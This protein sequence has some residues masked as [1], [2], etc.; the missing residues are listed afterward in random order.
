MS[1]AQ[2]YPVLRSNVDP[3]SDS[4]VRNH[5]A[6]SAALGEVQAALAK[7]NLSGGDKYRQR[8]LDRGRILPRQRIEMLLDRDSHFLEIASLAGYGMKGEVPGTSLIGG[9]GLVSGVECV[10]TANEAT[11]IRRDGVRIPVEWASGKRLRDIAGRNV[12]LRFDVCHA[13]M[14]ALDIAGD[15]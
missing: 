5:E 3:S 9:V 12:R 14:Y 6:N 1:Q 10:I 4:F 13:R 2:P 11:E 15:E 7:A 8:H